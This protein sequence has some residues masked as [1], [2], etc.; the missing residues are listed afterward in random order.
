MTGTIRGSGEE[1]AS[2]AGI[3]I[4]ATDRAC[5]GPIRRALT[6]PAEAPQVNQLEHLQVGV[7]E[8][9]S[10]ADRPGPCRPRRRRPGAGQLEPTEPT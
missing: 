5:R 7:S 3:W 9:G 4:K 10:G 6:S 8:T 1:L 2:T